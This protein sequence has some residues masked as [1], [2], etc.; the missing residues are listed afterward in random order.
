MKKILIRN[1]TVSDIGHIM[2]IEHESFCESVHEDIAV[3]RDRITTFPDGFL[4]LE[5]EG[6]VCGYISSEIWNYSQNIREDMFYLDHSINKVH[7]VTGSE[8]YISSIGILKRYRG[9]GYGK[10]LFSELSRKITEKYTIS[11]MI[12]IVSAQWIA[13][14][15]IYENDGFREIK[16]IHGFFDDVTHSDAIVMRKYT[17]DNKTE[18][19]DMSFRR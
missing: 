11:S 10:L 17:L 6:H 15:R 16:R 1:A 19:S 7:D 9:K 12:L 13:A 14:K 2:D 3:F 4:V 8:L 18:F 5:V